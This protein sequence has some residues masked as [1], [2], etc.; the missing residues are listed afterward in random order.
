MAIILAVASI[1]AAGL[2]AQ[3]ALVFVHSA[4]VGSPSRWWGGNGAS[5]SNL[6]G[7]RDWSWTQKHKRAKGRTGVGDD[8]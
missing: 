3:T 8:R 2:V 7:G 1:F 4:D 5:R 6:P